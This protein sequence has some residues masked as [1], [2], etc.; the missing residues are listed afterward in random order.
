MLNT[1]NIRTELYNLVISTAAFSE[2]NTDMTRYAGDSISSSDLPRAVIEFDNATVE[3]ESIGSPRSVRIESSFMIHV[4]TSSESSMDA[5]MN[6][7]LNAIDD[8]TLNGQVQELMVTDIDYQ[9]SSE[10]DADYGRGTITITTQTS[11][12]IND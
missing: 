10:A 11:S 3:Y 7:I 1:S 4:Y 8:R 9:F 6:Q 12:T 2:S 5:F